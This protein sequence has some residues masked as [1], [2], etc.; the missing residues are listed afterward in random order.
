M[1]D[2]DDMDSPD[3]NQGPFDPRPSLRKPIDK[4]NED[5]VVN[6]GGDEVNLLDNDGNADNLEEEK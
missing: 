4:E 5:D 3:E 1:L 2:G 6:E